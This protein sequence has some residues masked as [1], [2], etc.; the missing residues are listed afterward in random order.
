ML[1]LILGHAFRIAVDQEKTFEVL[2]DNDR[3]VGILKVPG[4]CKF[5]G[6]LREISFHELSTVVHIPMSTTGQYHGYLTPI[7]DLPILHRLGLIIELQ[8]IA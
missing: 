7:I 6:Y 2:P 3:R 5:I 4:V 8:D 1:L